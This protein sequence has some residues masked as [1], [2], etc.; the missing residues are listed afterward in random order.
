MSPFSWG[1]RTIAAAGVLTAP[2]TAVDRRARDIVLL[3]VVAP[4][5]DQD[6]RVVGAVG[7]GEGDAL[8]VRR[9][10]ARH[11]DLLFAESV[12]VEKHTRWCFG[13]ACPFFVER[14]SWRKRFLEGSLT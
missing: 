6:T 11:S 7:A 14:K 9:A 1:G 4:D 2:L 5:V 10:T 8:G 13:S 3:E 12:S